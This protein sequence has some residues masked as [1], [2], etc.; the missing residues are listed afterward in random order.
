MR[1]ALLLPDHSQ[2]IHLQALAVYVAA[3]VERSLMS[4]RWH[5]ED[6]GY[7]WVDWPT[8]PPNFTEMP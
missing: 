2:C 8:F 1:S 3:W 4:R 7:S 6:R 5:T